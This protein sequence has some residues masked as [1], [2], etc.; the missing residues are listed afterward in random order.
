[1]PSATRRP[2][3]RSAASSASGPRIPTRWPP[4]TS[5]WR[6]SAETT[7]P[8]ATRPTRRR[9][10]RD[11]AVKG[12]RMLRSVGLAGALTLAACD[13]N[14][15]DA[16]AR[17]AAAEAK[18]DSAAAAAIPPGLVEVLTLDYYLRD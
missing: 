4:C 10:V 7:V 12:V 5:S 14:A 6:F 15:F 8:R 2:T 17:H 18:A 1:M 11:G 13:A 9:P 3:G 16:R